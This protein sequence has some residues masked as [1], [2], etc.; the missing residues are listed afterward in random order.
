MATISCAFPRCGL[1]KNGALRGCS[2]CSGRLHHAC[3][4]QWCFDNTVADPPGDQAFCWSCVLV[5]PQYKGIAATANVDETGDLENLVNA[6]GTDLLALVAETCASN[7][8]VVACQQSSDSE[9]QLTEV[10]GNR[11]AEPDNPS[12][13]AGS[14][15]PPSN[16]ETIETNDEFLRD[17]V[18]VL[19][20]FGVPPSWYGGIVKLPRTTEDTTDDSSTSVYI[21]FDDGELRRF[22][23]GMIV[24]VTHMRARA[25]HLTIVS[26]LCHR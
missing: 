17:G 9:P 22:T 7:N 23:K 15:V 6:A 13:D 1:P 20:S 26:V 3:F 10:D 8:D 12:E 4:A 18:R 16:G 19:M 24:P 14:S 25:D 5:L 21:A 11:D 2:D